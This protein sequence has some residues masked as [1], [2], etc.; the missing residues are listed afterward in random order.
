MAADD[1][2]D[3]SNGL[4]KLKPKTKAFIALLDSDPKISHTQAYLDTHK[5]TNRKAANVMAAQVL[6]KP[7]VKIYRKQTEQ[8]AKQT[9]V[10]VMDNAIRR[11]D[12]P[13]MQRLA[14][15][16]ANSILDRNLGKA[17]IKQESTTVNTNLN[18]QASAELNQAFTDFL[19][20]STKQ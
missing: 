16:A 11:K 9:A 10:A 12:I 13:A 4:P 18:I 14:L 17:T 15:D 1:K 7:S 19:K 20:G 8:R 5:T 2:P 3:L 6:A